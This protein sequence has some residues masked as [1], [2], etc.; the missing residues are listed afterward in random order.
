[1]SPRAH[2]VLIAGC[3]IGGFAANI[4][5]DLIKHQHRDLIFS[6][7]DGFQGQHHPSQFP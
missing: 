4:G 1:M 5:I 7:Q 2:R 6:G 3:G